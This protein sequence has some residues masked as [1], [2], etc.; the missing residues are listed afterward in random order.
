MCLPVPTELPAQTIKDGK[1]AKTF[2]METGPVRW[3]NFGPND[4]NRLGRRQSRL[5]Q[6]VLRRIA[7]AVNLAANTEGGRG[8]PPS[9]RAK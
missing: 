3:G 7:L 6:L 5:K 8:C 1:I 2:H 4:P 9:L